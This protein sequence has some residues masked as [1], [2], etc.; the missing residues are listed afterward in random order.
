MRPKSFK[1][2][3]PKGPC[4][5]IAYIHWPQSTYIGTTVRPKYI[6][7]GYMHPEGTLFVSTWFRL[8]YATR[9]SGDVDPQGQGSKQR[10]LGF[11]V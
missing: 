2:Y 5:H 11:R 6:L 10:G 1:E 9:I 8:A 7:F 4:T 3:T